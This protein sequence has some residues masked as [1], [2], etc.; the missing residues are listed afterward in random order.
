MPMDTQIFH[1]DFVWG[2]IV[3][4]MPFVFMAVVKLSA[5]II[6]TVGDVKFESLI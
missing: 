6:S 3:A 1:N 4:C 2:A 5:L